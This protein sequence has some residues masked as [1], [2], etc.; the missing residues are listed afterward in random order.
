MMTIDVQLLPFPLD[1]E[2]LSSRTVVVIDVLRATS[3]MV[4]AVAEGAVEIVPV[5]AVEE[6]FQ[7]ARSYPAGTTLL[8]G[9]RE[10]RT[11]EGFNLGNSPREYIAERVKGK[12]LILTTTNGTR[13][14]QLVSKGYEVMAGSFFNIDATAQRCVQSNRDLLI[15]LSGDRGNFSIE[16]AACGGML[17]EE[18]L[19]KSENR[20]GLADAAHCALILYQRFEE[21]LLGAFHLSRHGKELIDVG[22]ADDLI[23][24]AQT[25]ITSLVPTLRDGVIK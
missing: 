18:I 13:A 10:S 12:R 23:Y 1:P 4:Q 19:K 11:I 20:V 16:D 25:N 15:F 22:A 7:R 21:N 24:C 5:A 17:V 2:F 9:E 14:F 6:A 8:G 3:V